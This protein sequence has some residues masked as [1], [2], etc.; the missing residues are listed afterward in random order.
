VSTLDATG[1]TPRRPFSG[2]RARAGDLLLQGVAA[3][4][5]VYAVVLVGVIAWKVV[6]GA[7]LSLSGVGL[8]F[9]SS[10]GWDPLH[11]HFGAAV[12]LFGTAV[13][14]IGALLLATPLAI[15][16]AIFLTELAPRWIRA[17]VTAL[18][19]TLA[20]IPSVVI[21]LWGIIV[22]GPVLSRHV[23]PALHSAVGFIPLFGPA[24]TGS[25]IFTAIVVLTIMILPIIS[26]ISR[27][28]FLGVPSELKEAALG[29]GT[30]RWEMVRGVM[31]PY[32]RGGV[33]AAMILGLGRAVGEAIAVS[34]VIGA[35]TN[36]IHWNLFDAGNT[37]A[38]QLANDY[39]SA[40]PG[41]ETSSLFY[42]ALILL[43]FSLAISFL[44][45]VI[46]RRVARRQGLAAR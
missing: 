33:A 12:F 28:L 23:L 7:R 29:L 41:L 3:A 2:R 43:V 25:S 14:S 42:L 13:T 40:D 17:P 16:I 20:A 27:E 46:V 30:T 21:G 9:L 24:S 34:M 8:G 5:A 39:A 31:L 19:E 37:I 35:A 44:A 1:A 11:N 4:A 6:Q 45:Q 38:A 15:G 36:G 32:A 26:S 22:L 10:V 18:V